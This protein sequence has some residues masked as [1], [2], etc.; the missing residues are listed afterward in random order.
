MPSP[1]GPPPPP[2]PTTTE[3]TAK[4]V[5]APRPPRVTT[6]SSKKG[7]FQIELLINNGYPYKDHWAYWVP[8]HANP[9]IGVKIHVTGDVRN[10]FQFEIKRSHDFRSSDDAPTKRVP[11]QWV[12]AEYFDEKAMFNNGQSMIDNRPVCRFE[13]SVFSIKAP[14]K[15]LNSTVGQVS[16]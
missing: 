13:A 1:P 14:G 4:F 12:N 11:L 9:Q 3:R 5:A 6:E 8:S 7:D 2:P 10:G 16:W 15:S